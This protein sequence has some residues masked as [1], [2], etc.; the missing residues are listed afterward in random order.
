[1]NSIMKTKSLLSLV[2]D[3]FSLMLAGKMCLLVM[4][5]FVLSG[6]GAM[7]T[8]SASTSHVQAAFGYPIKVYFPKKPETFS[9]GK[10][11]G[12]VF[13]VERVSPTKAVATYALQLL[14][15]GPTL[16]ELEKGYYSDL[17][18]ALRGSSTCG[19]PDFRLVLD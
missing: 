17:N 18:G 4:L 12:E 13:P 1:M 11:F 14:I 8:A 2:L 10:L 3:R 9:Y 7:M 5:L 15:A 6:S 19:G 16:E